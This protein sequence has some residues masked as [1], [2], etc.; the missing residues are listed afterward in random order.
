MVRPEYI[1]SKT[2]SNQMLVTLDSGGG[3]HL[4]ESLVLTNETPG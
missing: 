2:P 1:I 4:S 3:S